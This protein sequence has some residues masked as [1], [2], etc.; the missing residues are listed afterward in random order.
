MQYGAERNGFH[1]FNLG[2]G[3]GTSVLELVSAFEKASGVTIPIV[4]TARRVG[5][6]EKL[7]AIPKRANDEL[8]WKA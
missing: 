4:K 7:L 3:N 8:K 6:A 1:V 2:T 5:D